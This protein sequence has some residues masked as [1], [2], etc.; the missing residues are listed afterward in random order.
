[1]LVATVPKKRITSSYRL[2]LPIPEVVSSQ[3]LPCLTCPNSLQIKVQVTWISER[4]YQCNV[5]EET[6]KMTK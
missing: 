3:D 6:D 5:E 4:F 1:M 2:L